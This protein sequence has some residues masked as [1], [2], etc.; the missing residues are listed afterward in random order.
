[1][2]SLA[3]CRP[4]VLVAGGGP[5]GICAAI[6]AARNGARTLL[7]E[8]YGFLGGTA[9]A[10]SVGPFAPFHHGDEQVIK[11]IPQEII[12]RLYALGGSTGHMKVQYSYGSGTYMCWFD[13]ETYK[14]AALQL[15]QEAGA[16]IL[17]HTWASEAVMEGDR[18]GGLIVQNKSGRQMI[19][20]EVVIDTTG[21][22]D[23]IAASGARFEFGRE[24]DG[25]AQAMTMLFEMADVDIPAVR[26][27]IETHP[28]DFEWWS[29]VIPVH[30]L[31][32][33]FQ[34]EHFVAQ[35][36]LS[37]VKEAMST[38]ELYL[39]RNSVL[40][41]TTLWPRMITFNSTRV[42]GKR[43]TDARELTE[44][45]IDARRQVMSLAEFM[46]KHTPGF[47]RAH[48]VTTGVQIGVRESRRLVGE[49]VLTSKDVQRGHKFPDGIAR[50]YFPIDIHSPTSGE[51]YRSGGSTWTELEDSYDIPYRC[52]V[53]EKVEGLLVAGR[54][55]SASHEAVGST[56]STGSC[57]ALGQATGTAAALAARQG[58]LPRHVNIEELRALLEGQGA[59][60][61][62]P[63]DQA[64]GKPAQAT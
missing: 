22:G 19:P 63:E 2:L 46:K 49:Y 30:P 33:E 10:A 34:Q 43:G 9:T 45:E 47:A 28:Q 1:M 17:L 25:R 58:I 32:P 42:I 60:I 40:L 53:P 15:V 37:M 56:R 11:G 55:I 64:P 18:I 16:D 41:L 44:A 27:Y 24:G 48:I 20:A 29:P 35:G 12:E 59:S 23:V 5:S 51:G 36:F 21:D 31:R 7:I 26:R 50:G 39:G 4:Q 8:R 57:M 52:C 13:R 14:H 62:R 3:S 6:A 61:R 54:C 38:G